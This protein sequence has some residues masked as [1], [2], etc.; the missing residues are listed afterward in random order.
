M[1][2][3]PKALIGVVTN[4]SVLLVVLRRDARAN[5]VAVP[6]AAKQAAAQASAPSS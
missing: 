3:I 4:N 2:L 6:I 5:G 1:T